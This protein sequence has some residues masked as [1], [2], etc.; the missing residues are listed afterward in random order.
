MAGETS[1]P[2]YKRRIQVTGRSTFIV[3]LP[4]DWVLSMGGGPG[5][6]VVIEPQP[7]GS[8]K[9]VM[10]GVEAG[11]GKLVRTLDFRG[12][13]DLSAAIRNIISSYIAGYDE[14]RLVFNVNDS[15]VASK[16]RE[17]VEGAI[18]GFNVL[19]EEPGM[20]IFYSVVDPRSLEFDKAF[21][22]AARV[23]YSMLSDL[24][25]AITDSNR[26]LLALIVERDQLV[27]KLYL[28]IA[29]QLTQTLVGRYPLR[30]LGINTP[31]EA[32]HL[33]LASKSIER[34]ADHAYLIASRA[35]SSPDMGVIR[36]LI[37]RMEGVSHLF[38]RATDA[39]I[40]VD[41]A[42]AAGVARG[43]EEF[44]KEFEAE[45]LRAPDDPLYQLTLDSLR[46]VAGYC[47][48]LAEA[49]FDLAA[50]REAI[51]GRDSE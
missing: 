28:Y 48:D 36:N 9:L 4:K 37:A 45:A 30:D 46:R 44:R 1:R 18:L 12:G 32:L 11:R 19:E 50:L 25:K 15:Q 29:R 43:V 27:D 8:L 3:S 23:A 38:K 16:V 35:L 31:A 14:V 6:Q 10:E 26:E 5:S 34:V 7:D 33:F 51:G 22:R 2:V 20:L 49:V 40:H 21:R 17:V 41:P 39:L 24:P 47:L 42:S 13:L